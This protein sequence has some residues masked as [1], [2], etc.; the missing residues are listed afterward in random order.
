MQPLDIEWRLCQEALFRQP[1]RHNRSR[2]VAVR[3]AQAALVTAMQFRNDECRRIPTE[4]AVRLRRV[5]R[6]GVGPHTHVANRGL[7]GSHVLPI[8]LEPCAQTSSRTLSWAFVRMILDRFGSP[9]A[10]AS[11]SL[12]ACPTLTFAGIGGVN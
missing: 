6:N 7:G 5:R 10:S 12:S 1:P 3:I 4:S 9:R 8:L 11:A 2:S